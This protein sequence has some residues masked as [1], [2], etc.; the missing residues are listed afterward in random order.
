MSLAFI[1]SGK[2]EYNIMILD[3]IMLTSAAS[4]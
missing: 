1:L 4:E 3:S 2:L